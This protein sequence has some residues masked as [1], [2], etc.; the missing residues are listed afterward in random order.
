MDYVDNRT[1]VYHIVNGERREISVEVVDEE[2]AALLRSRTPEERLKAAA[3]HARYLRRALR[4][5][6]ESLHPEWSAEQI[7]QELMRRYLGE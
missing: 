3:S 1:G 7:Q 5:Q 2:F 4:S 6:L